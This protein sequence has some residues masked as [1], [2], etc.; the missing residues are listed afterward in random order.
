MTDDLHDHIM[1][2]WWDGSTEC[3]PKVHFQSDQVSPLMAC[4]AVKVHF[5]GMH[6][7]KCPLSWLKSDQVSTFMVDVP[8]SVHLHVRSPC[9]DDPLV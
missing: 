4:V 3:P 1:V 5:H 2:N 9:D 8:L 7:T 6:L